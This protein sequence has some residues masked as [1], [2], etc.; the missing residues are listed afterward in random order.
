VRGNIGVVS[1]KKVIYVPCSVLYYEID[2]TIILYTEYRRG[3]E[4]KQH[5]PLTS[6]N[7]IFM[8]LGGPNRSIKTPASIAIR[9]I[10]VHN[11]PTTKK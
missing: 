2:N 6:L 4:R 5:T 3:E 9:V 7:E 1:I 11:P 10:E 8:C